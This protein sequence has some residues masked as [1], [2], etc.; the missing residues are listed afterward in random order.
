MYAQLA[1]LVAAA[2]AA[3]AITFNTPSNV[4]VGDTIQISWTSTSTDPSVFSIE[5]ANAPLLGN[6]IAIANN[7]QTSS[8]SAP[9]SIP[10]VP[11]A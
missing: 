7:V 6:Q 9:A 3:T 8:G 5:L 1:L 4:A 11:T 10:V 2:K